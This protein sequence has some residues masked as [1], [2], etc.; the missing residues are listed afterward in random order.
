MGKGYRFIA[1]RYEKEPRPREAGEPNYD[2]QYGVYG[3]GTVWYSWTAPK[4]SFPISTSSPGRRDA[5]TRHR[6]RIDPHGEL[7]QPG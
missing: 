6:G 3:Q 4:T 5:R 7:G 1:L 2:D